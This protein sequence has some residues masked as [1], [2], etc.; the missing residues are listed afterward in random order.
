MK[1]HT[2]T[3]AVG[4]V[5]RCKAK[6]GLRHSPRG[7]QTRTQLSSLLRR[8]GS[9]SLQSSFVVRH[10]IPNVGVDGWVSRAGYVMGVAISNVLQ[11]GAFVWFENTHKFLVKV[12]PMPNWRPMK[13]L[14]V[15]VHFLR[16]GGLLDDWPVEVILSLAFV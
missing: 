13:Q 7:L 6:A 3:P 9:L 10:A 11:P 1:P 16:S 14:A 12:L 5:C 8:P 15:R 4:V 2:I